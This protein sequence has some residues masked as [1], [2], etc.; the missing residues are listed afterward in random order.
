MQRDLQLHETLLAPDSVLKS[1][2]VVAAR[3]RVLGLLGAG[4]MGSV[5]RA[6]DVELD[7][8]V[9]LK[10]LR[11]ELATDVAA[12]ARFRR[13]VRLARKV[14]HANVARTYD[15]GADGAMHFLTMEL[16]EGE[17]LAH[18]IRVKGR[19]SLAEALRVAVE[20]ARGLATAHVVGVVHR[21]LKPDNVMLAGARV[22]I[23]DFGIARSTEGAANPGHHESRNTLGAVGTPAYMA[24]EQVEGRELDG[25]ADVYALGTLLFEALTGRLPFESNSA[26]NVA[27]MRLTTEPPDPR[28]FDASIPAAH[29]ELVL[30]LLSRRREQRPDAQSAL[31]RIDALRGEGS[32]LAGAIRTPTRTE[33]AKSGTAWRPSRWIVA[34]WVDALDDASRAM[35]SQLEESLD[36]AFEGLAAFATVP[37][38]EVRAAGT[39]D[40]KLLARSVG[41]DLLLCVS[42]R[43]SSDRHRARIRL[44]ERTDGRTLWQTRVDGQTQDPFAFED[45]LALEIRNH[46]AERFSTP[47]VA[48]RG[49][50]DPSVREVLSRARALLYEHR[51]E[52]H[53]RA[54]AVLEEALVASPDDPWLMGRLGASLIR[55]LSFPRGSKT[56]NEDIARAEELCLRALSADATIGDTYQTLGILRFM[57]GRMRN[58]VRAFREAIERDPFLAESHVYLARILTDAGRDEEAVERAHL[59]LRLDPT[60][61]PARWALARV[62]LFEGPDGVE[63]L[64][65]EVEQYA[66]GAYITML[67]RVFHAV[68]SPGTELEFAL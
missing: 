38:A 45:A 2:Q 5:H 17:S 63:D 66:P 13:E 49:P 7:E 46:F 58:S 47:S 50:R 48:L 61:T 6:L 35:A 40:E 67:F 4:G 39:K 53:D 28:S 9:A 30:S 51:P 1:G 25:R 56:M 64:L 27:A 23:T 14:T 60:L 65:R 3:Y 41:A 10:V 59:A 68:G 15:L 55:R 62:A 18:T 44:V 36:D 32:A 52:A 26:F 34:T 16:I 21:D 29:A 31:E 12:L 24:P 33:P 11:A 20:I 22:C 42:V 54:I 57:Q 19:L 37:R 43:S 8:E